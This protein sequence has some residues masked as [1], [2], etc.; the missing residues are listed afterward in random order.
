MKAVAD[1]LFSSGYT[2]GGPTPPPPPTAAPPYSPV[3][4]LVERGI[5]QL[6]LMAKGFN[7]NNNNSNTNNNNLNGVGSDSNTSIIAVGNGK[8]VENKR[9]SECALY[10]ESVERRQQQATNGAGNKRRW[11]RDNSQA[12][13]TPPIVKS[14]VTSRPSCGCRRSSVSTSSPSLLAARNGSN[15]HSNG[16]MASSD[17]NGA[18][19]FPLQ[20]CNER[21]HEPPEPSSGERKKHDALV[22]SSGGCSRTNPVSLRNDQ[23]GAREQFGR[24]RDP[25]PPSRRGHDEYSTSTSTKCGESQ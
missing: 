6:E 9:R 19:S 21:K 8:K 7:N 1:S 14:E 15:Q 17:N 25:V 4:P 12:P 13:P 2:F 23:K 11:E 10:Q 24:L 22:A 5:T 16:T 18:S 3:S 20:Q